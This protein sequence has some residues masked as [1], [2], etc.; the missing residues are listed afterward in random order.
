MPPKKVRTRYAKP[1]QKRAGNIKL[2]RQDLAFFGKCLVRFVKEEARKDASKSS[3]IPDTKRFFDSFSYRVTTSGVEILS[4]WPWMDLIVNGTGGPF[5]MTWLN[6]EAYNKGGSPD[7]G[8]E[9]PGM[10][11]RP[12]GKPRSILRVPMRSSSG[13]M[14]IRTAPLSISDAWIHPGI[15][16]HN[17]VNRAFEKARNACFQNWA[18]NNLSETLTR[19]MG[20]RKR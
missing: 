7:G 1:I 13:E 18:K 19:E 5:P 15:A 14:V 6:Q 8:A 16:K 10:K 11:A 17:F 2:G 12:P 20:K 4:T 3:Q 9:T